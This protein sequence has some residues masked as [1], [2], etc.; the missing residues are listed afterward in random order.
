[1]VIMG[2][3]W[4]SPHFIFIG[5]FMSKVAVGS[6][7]EKISYVYSNEQEVNVG[8]QWDI[9]W[10]ETED[11]K[12]VTQKVTPAFPIEPGNE[13][14]LATAVNWASQGG[15]DQKT[16]KPI[17]KKH[18][19]DEVD[20]API[21]N[22]KVLSLEERG[23]GG[24]AYKALIGKYYVDLREDVL[25]DTLLQVG[26]A[27]GGILQGEYIWA[28]MGSQMK[29]VRIGSEV[30]RLL[31]EF[32]ARSA[33]K[34]VGK[35]DLEVGGVYRDKKKNT[36]IFIGYVNTVMYKEEP[37]PSSSWRSPTEKAKFVFEQTVIKKGMLFYE[38]YDFEGIAKSVK[39]MTKKDSSYQYKLKKT[40][41]YIE[42]VQEV[43]LLEGMIE[44]L[45]TKAV[46]QIKDQIL[47]YTGH[48]APKQGY[49]KIDDWHL[50][51]TISYHSEHLNLYPFEGTPVDP[52]DVKK[53][54]LFS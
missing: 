52:F 43:V 48:K 29:L 9:S 28:K 20:N 3:R 25:M 23:N 5:V 50:S 42:K 21:K 6:I 30:H 1:M 7:P 11:H 22:V 15:W 31:N 38:V 46:Q 16:N 51:S 49:G 27:P 35:K 34:P 24:R 47:E 39:E 40:H 53:F 41:T 26:I 2:C 18:H 32:E 4:S 10:Y 12:N 19:V 8:C 17:V 54:L 44:K 36:A 37:C 13:K 45:R 33:V 14:T